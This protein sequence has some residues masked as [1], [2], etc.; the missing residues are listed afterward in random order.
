MKPLVLRTRTSFGLCVAVWAIAALGLGSMV[1]Q[2]F[3][4]SMLQYGPLFLV[5]AWSAWMVFGAPSVRID[6]DAVTLD[7]VLRSVRIPW[8]DVAEVEAGLS[9]RIVTGRGAFSSWAAPGGADTAPTTGLAVEQQLAYGNPAALQFIRSDSRQ[10]MDTILG[11]D[12]RAIS[13]ASSVRAAIQQAWRAFGAV[14]GLIAEPADVTV[15]WHRLR[16][17]VLAALV[18]IAVVAAIL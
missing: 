17:A 2:G 13:S 14:N 7:N 5:A 11:F 9:L 4:T 6:D 10:Q 8:N 3:W 16:L 1:A 15:H 12:R 18:T